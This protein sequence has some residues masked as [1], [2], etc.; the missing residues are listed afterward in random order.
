MGGGLSQS[1]D[2]RASCTFWGMVITVVVTVLGF[3][4]ALVTSPDVRSWVRELVGPSASSTTVEPQPLGSLGLNM[5]AYCRA[6][7]FA[8][9][10]PE[11]PELQKVKDWTCVHANGTAEPITATGGLSFDG[12]CKE[13]H[14]LQYVAINTAP[15]DIWNG[16]RCVAR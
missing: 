10:R 4:L 12:A 11:G 8:T 3:V 16:V 7:G 5:L 9:S 15:N 1:H 14:G 6:H 2:R 13:Q